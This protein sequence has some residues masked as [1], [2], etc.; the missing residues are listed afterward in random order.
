[1]QV[2]ITAWAA[3]D[4]K[5]GF[6]WVALLVGG[7]ALILFGGFWGVI[8]GVLTTIGETAPD[9]RAGFTCALAGGAAPFLIGLLLLAQGIRTQRRL[10]KLRELA[11]FARQHPHVSA[12][13]VAEALS[14][15][16]HAAELLVLDAASRGVLVDDLSET[17]TTDRS[18]RALADT[19]VASAVSP[20][21]RV[22]P[23]QVGALPSGT[24]PLGLVLAGT[25]SVEGFLGAG[26]MGHVYDVRH[27]RTG[28]RYALKTM[29]PDARLSVD[30]L[31][32]FERE[33][34]AASAL[35]HPGIVAVHDFD[36]HT[37]EHGS[38]DFL[39]MDRL[40]GETLEDR[41]RKRGSL[42]WAEASTIAREI[43]SALAAAHDAGLLHRDVKPANVFLARDARGERAVL[44]D[45]GL[46]KP[47]DDAL[48]SRITVT[49]AAVGTPLYMSPEQARGDALDVRTDVYGLAAT[50]YEMVTGAPPFLEPTVAR[51][52]HR[53]LSEPA[54]PAS[55][56]APRPL[57]AELDALLGA[58]L[59]KDPDARPSDARA[60]AAALGAVA[61]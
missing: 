11:A 31:R 47:I 28:R 21:A 39:V 32:R 54:L 8:G 4:K 45:F 60:F 38:L 2:S 26:G 19:R 58:A 22:V 44:L 1:M 10:A 36:R 55:Q 3:T 35:G 59:A 30:A 34:R 43:A 18:A 57:P 16:R 56:L 50:L 40:E 20:I 51:A 6:R 52:Y 14:I 48:S 7:I 33:A 24:L 37:F 5:L 61:A 25:W 9:R 29:L 27:V 53:L 15:S 46:A 17:S 13:A 42:E 49:G 41:L 23:A 12:E